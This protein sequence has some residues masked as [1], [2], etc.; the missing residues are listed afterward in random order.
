[1]TH[2]HFDGFHDRPVILQKLLN[3]ESDQPLDIFSSE[4]AGLVV[5]EFRIL[6]DQL[7][8]EADEVFVDLLAA[9]TTFLQTIRL[10]KSTGMNRTVRISTVHN[11]F[12]T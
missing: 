8:G 3:A 5:A 4:G 6:E 11:Y 9:A 7:E 12:S 2:L 10:D 1:M